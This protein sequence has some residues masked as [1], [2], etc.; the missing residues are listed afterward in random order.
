[1]NAKKYL[2]QYRDKRNVCKRYRERI[3]QIENVLRSVN[4]DGLPRGTNTGDPTMQAALSLTVLKEELKAAE[5]EAEQ[6]AQKIADQIE[7]LPDDKCR[8]LLF[9]RYILLMRWEDVARSLDRFRPYQEYELKHVV[10]YLHR[11]ALQQFEE[12]NKI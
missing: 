7:A 2:Q 1:M 3:A 11:K 12:V 5:I 9:D 6:T 10:G 4:L 8:E